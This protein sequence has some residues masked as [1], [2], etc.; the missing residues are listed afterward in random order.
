MKLKVI[1]TYDLNPET[2]EIKLLSKEEVTVDTTTET[3]KTTKK[4]A[5]KADTNTE[6]IVTLDTNKLLLTQGVVDL[7]QI[8]ED[9]RVDVRYERKGSR[10]LPIIGTDKAFNLKCG[11][12]VTAKLTVSYRGAA[13]EKLAA[14]G[15]VFKLEPTDKEGIFYLVGDKEPEDTKIPEEIINIENELDIEDL[16]DIEDTLELNKFDFNL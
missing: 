7:L 9:C 11:N 14:Y 2:G 10:S 5:V 6:P 1:F 8:D 13:N 4:T 16:S 3:K 15:T 12:K